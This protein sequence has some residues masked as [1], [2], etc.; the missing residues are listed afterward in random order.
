MFK[1]FET[2]FF[3]DGTGVQ[4]MMRLVMFLII[5]V[6]LFVWLAL[7]IAGIVKAVIDPETAIVMVDFSREAMV[8]LAMVLAGKLGQA[9]VESKSGD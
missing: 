6:V 9:F 8:V 4:S 7:N 3:K 2:G 1:L 5:V